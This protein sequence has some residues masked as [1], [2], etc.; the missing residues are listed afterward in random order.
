MR[1]TIF[2]TTLAAVLS[3]PLAFAADVMPAN[4]M[5]VNAS[6]MTVYVFDKDVAG[7][8]K[9]ACSGGCLTLWPAVIATEEMPAAPYGTIQREDNGAKQL[10]YKGKPLYLYKEDKKPGDAAGDNFKNVWHAVKP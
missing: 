7:S 4:G 2:A 1:F 8:G 6:G 5:L 3:A 10:T 9:S